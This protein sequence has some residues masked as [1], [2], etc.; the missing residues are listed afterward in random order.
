MAKIKTVTTKTGDKGK[1]RLFSGEEV[2]KNS[3]RLAAYG[4]VDEL[5]CILGLARYYARKKDI[6]ESLLFLQRE[7]SVVSSELATTAAKLNKLP[8]RVDDKMLETLEEKREA[9]EER[10]S[11]PQGFVVC[12]DQLAAAY[13]DLARTVARRC[14]RKIAGLLEERTIDNKIVLVWFNRLSDYLYLMAR[15]EE[16]TPTMVKE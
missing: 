16:E 13:L 5:A 3:P 4:D 8:R 11:I 7:L 9:L 15:F 14:E 10:V 6:K 2:S 12:G 1:T